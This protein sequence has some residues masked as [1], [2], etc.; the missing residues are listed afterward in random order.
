MAAD[1]VGRALDHVLLAR[2]SLELGLGLHDARGRRGEAGDGQAH[3]GELLAREGRGRP[4]R[5]EGRHRGRIAARSRAAPWGAPGI[6][7]ERR[8]P[9]PAR[10]AAGPRRKRRAGLSRGSC[11]WAT[12]NTALRARRA[13]ASSESGSS[14]TLSPPIVAMARKRRDGTAARQA[15]GSKPPVADP[16]HGRVYHVLEGRRGADLEV[17][18]DLAQAGEAERREIEHVRDDRVRGEEA[19]PAGEGCGALRGELLGLLEARGTVVAADAARD[20]WCSP[21]KAGRDSS[22][23]RGRAPLYS[24]S[25]PRFRSRSRGGRACGHAWNTE[26]G[27]GKIDR[28]WR[29]HA[30]AEGRP[31]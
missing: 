4:P 16:G 27:A 3:A 12:A 29:S 9:P 15:E 24:A 18:V 5:H 6:R 17:L 31:R 28:P 8:I 26:R 13:A 20:Q 11:G 25:S 19:R 7:T 30:R 22:R 10:S 14:C 2:R 1:E 21:P 23:F